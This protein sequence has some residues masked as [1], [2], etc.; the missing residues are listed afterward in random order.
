MVIALNRNGNG[1]P[2]QKRKNRVNILNQ[3]ETFPPYMIV[4]ICS[5]GS[6]VCGDHS[7]R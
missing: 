5:N 4:D 6:I 2:F 1:I 7:N 3:R